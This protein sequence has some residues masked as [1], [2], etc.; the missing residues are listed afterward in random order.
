[1]MKLRLKYLYNAIWYQFTEFLKTFKAVK[2]RISLIGIDPLKAYELGIDLKPNET[3]RYMNFKATFWAIF[4]TA[5]FV[6]IIV[7]ALLNSNW[8]AGPAE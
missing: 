2:R 3:R 5:V 8:L 6:T 1:M 4:L 7:A